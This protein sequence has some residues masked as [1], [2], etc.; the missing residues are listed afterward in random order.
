MIQPPRAI[1]SRASCFTALAAALL[2]LVG[3][4]VSDRTGAGPGRATTPRYGGTAVV[5]LPADF[6][7][8]DPVSAER[9]SEGE[10]IEYLLFAPLL[11]YDSAFVP[12]PYLATRWDTVRAGRDSLDLTF[13]LRT[14]VKWHDGV[15]TTA[16]DVVF[17]FERMTDPRSAFPY[18][19]LL[20]GYRRTAEL[21]D[22]S[23]VRFRLR[24]FPEFLEFFTRFGGLPEHLLKSIPPDQE[25]VAEYGQHPVGNGPFR[26]GP[27]VR[28]QSF[29]FE[30]NPDFP[31]ALGGRPYLDRLVHRIIPEAT[32]RYTEL[33]SGNADLMVGVSADMADRIRGTPG[34]S[35]KAAHTSTWVYI[36]WNTRLPIFADAAVRRALTMAIDRGALTR[37]I[38][39][40][41]AAAGRT[42]VTPAH[43]AFDSTD[44]A[45]TLPYDPEGA[46]RLLDEAGWRDREGGGVR[47]DAAGHRLQFTLTCPI[48]SEW[49][50]AAQAVQAQLARVGVT[51]EVRQEELNSIIAEMDVGRAGPPRYQAA[52][53]NSTDY[54]GKTDADMFA[55]SAQ[56]RPFAATGYHSP[57]LDSLFDALDRT[58]DRAAARPLWLRYQRELAQAAPVTVLYYRPVLAGVGPRMRGVRLDAR[59]FYATAAGWWMAR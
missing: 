32:T 50:D 37:G 47:S 1:R 13:H 25:H 46:R 53:M 6:H 14:D 51:A 12:H 56:S 31:K 27:R 44:A 40:G 42:T 48:A 30:A 22:D 26:F 11:R 39:H 2:L 24:P 10:I 49:C 29:T 3:A 8:L 16:R 19:V 52:M 55:S 4:C 17:G 35:L 21:V 54:V 28:G 36:A 43:W 18:I 38:L 34:L 57:A 45:T 5:A 9:G 58:T 20:R 33:V 7:T 23:T 41:Y 59:G 15:P